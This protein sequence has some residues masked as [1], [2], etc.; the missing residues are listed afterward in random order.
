MAVA[1]YNR[2]RFILALGCTV[3]K[4]R[5]GALGTCG[6][7]MVT[8]W[9]SA[10]SHFGVAKRGVCVCV[11]SVSSVGNSL[12]DLTSIYDASSLRSCTIS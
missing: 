2:D 9:L 8:V 12:N 7:V 4:P 1:A 3:L 6:E 10:A 5:I 11:C